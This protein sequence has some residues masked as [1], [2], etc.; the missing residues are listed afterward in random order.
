MNNWKLTDQLRLIA[1]LH[2]W[3]EPLLR[4][5]GITLSEIDC[6][7]PALAELPLVT[8]AVLDRYY[9]AQPERMEPGLSIYR[10]SGTSSGIRKSIYY[11]HED[12]LRYIEAK[13]ASFLDWLGPRHAIAKAMADLGTGHAASTAIAIF[14]DL[15]MEAEAIPFTAPVEEHVAKLERYRP[16]L[17]YT[18]PSILEAIADALSSPL[19][20]G[21]RKIILVGELASAEWQANMAGRFGIGASDVLDTYGS[22]EIGAIAAFSHELGRYVLSDDVYGESLPAEALGYEPLG[23]DEGVLVLTSFSRAL[24][25]AMRYVTYDIVRD[26]RIVVHQGRTLH[27]FACMT[28]RIGPELKHGEKISLYDIEEAVHRHLADASLRVQVE[29][30]KLKLFIKSSRLDDSVASAIQHDVEHK[31]G[32][33]GM[34]IRNRLLQGIEVIHV[35]ERDQLPAGPVKAKKLY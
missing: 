9:Y 34:M 11:S 29:S 10:T 4:Q 25:P 35:S 19:S 22:I 28:K 3:Y 1:R 15:G 13:K 32:D 24:F 20:L 16:Q 27:T 23:P 8:A 5:S 26:F 12:D 31:I 18:M 7:P 6:S 30:N 17:L 33:I 2:P 14:Q 21:L